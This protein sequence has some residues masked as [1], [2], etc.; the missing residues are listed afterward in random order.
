MNH[1][2]GTKS[3]VCNELSKEI[4]QWCCERNIWITATYLEGS[5]NCIADYCSRNFNDQTEWQL[6]PSVFQKRSKFFG[7]PCID[8]FA[9]RLNAQLSRFVSWL[10]DPDAEAIDAFTLVWTDMFF[11]ASPP[12]PFLH[13]SSLFAENYCRRVMWFDCCTLL[14]NTSQPWF[15]KLLHMLIAPPVVLPQSKIVLVKPVSQEPHPLCNKLYLLYCRVSGKLSEAR[16]YRSTLQTLSSTAGGTLRSRNTRVSSRWLDYCSRRQI[17]PILTDVVTVLEFIYELYN[18]GKSYSLLN[19]TR[20]ALSS[21]VLLLDG[22]D[23]GSHPLI[24]RFLKGV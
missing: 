14:A 7:K 18:Q 15:A 2:G 16:D 17:N 11:Y 12:P 22:K 21:F 19:T 1:M 3:H 4:W 10:P 8:L 24:S 9:S 5:L 23:L 13:H 20:S 6:N